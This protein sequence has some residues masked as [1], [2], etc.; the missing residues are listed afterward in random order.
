MMNVQPIRRRALLARAFL[1]ATGPLLAPLVLALAATSSTTAQE[2][3]A[4]PATTAI[5]G[6][7]VIDGNGGP[8]IPDA[9]IVV[10][11]KRVEA[12]GPRSAVPVPPGA[13][14]VDAAGKFVTPGFVDTNVHLN[15]AFGRRWN[16]TNAR[17]WDRN[18]ELTL[19]S[20]QLHLKHGVTTVRDSYG[21]LLPGIQVA[22]P[23]RAA[24]S[25]VHA[26]TWRATSSGGA[27]PTPRPSPG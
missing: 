3:P 24:R 19:Q 10:R 1:L 25:L 18:A 15:L 16:D 20:A 12:V 21:A 13:Q 9:T 22:T 26:C 6:A 27:D 11:G 23:S 14:V 7:T 2:A 8:P 5:V 4:N 17:Y